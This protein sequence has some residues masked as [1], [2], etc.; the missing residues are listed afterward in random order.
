[1]RVSELADVESRLKWRQKGIFRLMQL[2]LF[3]LFDSS[4]QIKVHV[5]VFS[6]NAHSLIN[7]QVDDRRRGHPRIIYCFE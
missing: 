1:M 5:V 2:I 4:H 6:T 7:I 3:F